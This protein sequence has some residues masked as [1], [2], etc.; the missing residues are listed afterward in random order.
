MRWRQIVMQ[1]YWTGFSASS[2]LSFV[3]FSVFERERR[4][5]HHLIPPPDVTSIS[6]CLCTY[7]MMV[8]GLFGFQHC[9]WFSGA[10]N[11]SST[12]HQPLKDERADSAA[13]VLGTSSFPFVRYESTHN[14]FGRHHD[15]AKTCV[16]SD[17]ATSISSY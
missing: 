6:A 16:P 1:A 3:P 4:L 11:V 5:R 10:T 8:C 17:A 15:D 13:F 12:N 7:A 2:S 14:M 9:F